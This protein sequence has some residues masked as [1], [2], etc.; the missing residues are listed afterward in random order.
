MDFI[1]GVQPVKSAAY[2]LSQAMP[3]YA[4]PVAVWISKKLCDRM[5][6]TLEVLRN[7][8]PINVVVNI[9]QVPEPL[10]KYYDHQKLVMQIHPKS[11]SESDLTSANVLLAV[12]SIQDPQNFGSLIRTVM[13]MGIDG[14][15]MSKHNQVP[16]TPTVRRIAQGAAER[17]PILQVK[18]LNQWLKK[19]KENGYWLYGASAYAD[20][21]ITQQT[22]DKKSILIVGSEGGGMRKSIIS[23]CDFTVRI[24]TLSTF[25][26]L[27]VTQAT[28]M[29]VYAYRSQ[30]PLS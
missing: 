30:Y 9:D 19:Q 27:N 11:I 8:C 29:L 26:S 25:P 23:Q 17:L 5:Y 16:L 2:A 20:V 7:H 22:F 14:I 24:P 12:D 18:N 15:V 21:S 1:Y 4:N 10:Q 3:L 6:D 13:A 28:A